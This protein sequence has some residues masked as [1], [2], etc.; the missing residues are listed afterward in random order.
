M[1]SERLAPI[2]VVVTSG[3][4]SDEGLRFVE[5]GQVSWKIK[6]QQTRENVLEA[7]REEQSPPLPQTCPCLHC[8]SLHRSSRDFP[9]PVLHREGVGRGTRG[10]AHLPEPRNLFADSF[11]NPR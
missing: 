7:S 8:P 6:A 9:K 10:S 1:W 2:T 3:R 5:R 11:G 4:A